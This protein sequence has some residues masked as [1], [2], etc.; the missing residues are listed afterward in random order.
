MINRTR[1]ALRHALVLIAALMLSAVPAALL[2]QQPP[3]DEFTV[4]NIRIEGLQRISEGTV[5]NYLP[6]N[7]GDHLNAQRVRE[8][9]RA[10][11]ATGFFRDVELR[12]DGT[13]LV[14][15]V[16]E[17][18]SL[19]SVDIKGNKDIKT[20]DLQKSLRNVGLAAGKTFDRSTLDEVTQYLTDQY[21]SRGKY[22]VQIDSKVENLP[23]NRVRVNIN[24]KEGSR[25]KIRQINIV[26]NTVFRDKDILATLSLQTPNWQSWYKQSDRYARESLQGDLEKIQT[27]YQDRGYANFHIDSV[28][29]AIA[30]DKSDIFITVNITEGAVYKLG[31]IKLAGNM[32][33]PEA[34]LKTLLLLAPG[35]T[36]SQKTISATQEL[37]KNRLGA[38]GFYFAKVE[39]VPQNNEANRIVNLTLFVDPGSRV[40][41]RHINFTGTTRSD[42]ESLRREM[43]QLEGAWLSNVAL[44]RSKQRLQRLAFVESVEQSTEQVP[45]SPDL[46]DVN[47]AVKERPSAT[48]GGG[49]GYSAAQKLVLNGNLSDSNF[50]GGGD[51]VSLN[52]DSGAYN[53][54]YSFTETDPYR[55]VD[56]LSRTLSLSYRDSTQFVSE[57]SSFSSKNIALG[58]TY[59]YPIT[60]F[61]SI[62]AG[63]SLQRIDLLTFA[64]SSAEQAVN[65]VRS[66][67]HSYAGESV[68]T[69]IEPDGT[70]I[71]SSTALA[72]T[73]YSTVELTAGWQYDSRNRALF[74]DRGLRSAV[75]FVMVPPGLGV[76][77]WVGSYQFSGYLPLWRKFVLSEVIQVAYGKGLGGTTG[78][79]PYKRFYAGGPDTVRGYTEDT[80]GPVDS[81]GNPYGG[82]MLTVARTELVLPMPAKWQTSARV[83]VFYDMGNVFSNDGTKF[84]GEDL[85]TPI[86]Y[87]FSY[88]ALRDSTGL[89]V[90]W[91]APSLGIFR[92]SYGIALNASRGN[93][94]DFPDSTEGF[95]FS[96]GQSF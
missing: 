2:A 31:E 38:E 20:E 62:S 30:P 24:I 27:Y 74:A 73:Q 63:L 26:G 4:S 14:V 80:L 46:V 83:S 44:E 21:Y 5:Y 19:E 78:L 25:A 42:D 16:A 41:V 60:E 15:A 48:I 89:S 22:A 71:T 75:S 55:S 56:G 8:A 61:Q 76:R 33:V 37:I 53:K 12:R 40:Y 88:H 43:R 79:P 39:P 6:V 29:V 72:G 67:G 34:E 84:Y 95:Q 68:S 82:N 90:Q 51:F 45:G 13:V 96:V 3:S 23:D 35:Q 49:I 87:N 85:Q 58:L 92:F 86:N 59:G 17:R 91:L 28:Q 81:N 77:Y 50:F 70:T 66:N 54:I 11:Y 47:F 52:V 93:S 10:L 7:I 9:I 94:I 57:S 36:Y 1:R 32:I 65:W 64:A 69:F 18:P